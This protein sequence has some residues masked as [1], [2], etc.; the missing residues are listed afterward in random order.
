MIIVILLTI[1][2]LFLMFKR[3]KQVMTV[4]RTI[5]KRMKQQEQLYSI[6]SNSIYD[7][8]FLAVSAFACMMIIVNRADPGTTGLSI[9]VLCISSG[10]F[11]NAMC[12]KH[13]Y[14]D[15]HGFYY[16][17]HYIAYKELQDLSQTKGF[18]GFSTMYTVKTTH[19]DL[20]TISKAA[21]DYLKQYK[22]K[23]KK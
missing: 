9:L 22:G 18:L 6:K 1:I 8:G 10:E 5:Q 16:Y 17:H 7:W 19:G 13:F 3:I 15:R 2:G 20:F 14:Y 21:Y 12:I 23:S 4:Y 11:I